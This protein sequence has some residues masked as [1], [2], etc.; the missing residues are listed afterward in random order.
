[1]SALYSMAAAFPDMTFEVVH[2]GWAFLD[3]CAFQLQ[4]NPNIYANLEANPFGD[5]MLAKDGKVRVP[6]GPG[7]GAEPD[8]A[9]VE[10]YRQGPVGVVR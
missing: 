9:V 3:D 7:L 4:M 2:S 10:K 6:T 8:M 1:M 5:A